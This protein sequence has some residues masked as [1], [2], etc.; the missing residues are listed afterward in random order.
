MD[1]ELFKFNKVR[2]PLNILLRKIALD[3]R[4]FVH[5]GWGY[6]LVEN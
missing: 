1:K 6:V 2:N 3:L 4:D 5:K